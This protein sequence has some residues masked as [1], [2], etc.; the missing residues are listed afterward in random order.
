VY[1][2]SLQLE[3]VT[4]ADENVKRKGARKSEAEEHRCHRK[5]DCGEEQGACIYCAKVF[6]NHFSFF[7]IFENLLFLSQ[8]KGERNCSCVVLV[9]VLVLVLV[10]RNVREEYEEKRASV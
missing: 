4:H 2:S 10:E 3:P 8:I 7:S 6:I 5:R 9:L 1:L